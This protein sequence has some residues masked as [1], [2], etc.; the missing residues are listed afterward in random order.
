MTPRKP[1]TGFPAIPIE[2]APLLYEEF[3]RPGSIPIGEVRLKMEKVT[4]GAEI[5]GL[6]RPE[7]VESVIEFLRGL[8]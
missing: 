2:S 4:G 1:L 5:K 7:D 6:I 3:L 8:K